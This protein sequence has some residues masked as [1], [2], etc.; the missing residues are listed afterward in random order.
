[1]ETGDRVT[2]LRRVADGW[3]LIVEKLRE[4]KTGSKTVT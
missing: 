4:F 2:G 3:Q 1:L